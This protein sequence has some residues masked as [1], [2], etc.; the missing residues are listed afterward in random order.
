M[1]VDEKIRYFVNEIN[2]MLRKDD[3]E[4]RFDF[5]IGRIVFCDK[6]LDISAIYFGKRFCEVV[7][8]LKNM[9]F[10]LDNNKGGKYFEKK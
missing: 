9:L 10:D 3:R 5:D 8:Y 1:S 7:E 4:V 2:N 6:G